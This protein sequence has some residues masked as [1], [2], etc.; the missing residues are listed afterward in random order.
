MRRLLKKPSE[1][2]LKIFTVDDEE[3]YM[4]LVKANL[5]KLG[6][7]EVKAF[8]NG[9]ECLLEIVKNKPDVVIL[10]YV[11]KEGMNG[12]EI[13]KRIKMNYPDIEI[14]ILSGQEDVDIATNIIRQGATD[15]VVKNKM[16]FFNIGNTLSKI[17]DIV[18]SKELGIWKSRRIKLLYVLLIIAVWIV[19]GILLYIKIKNGVI[20]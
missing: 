16:S 4:E 11:I 6:Y 18:N 9:E 10:D 8:S 12:D 13:L 20:F 5:D 17:G 3:Y 1:R 19:G 2:P 14:I 7:H 15:Y